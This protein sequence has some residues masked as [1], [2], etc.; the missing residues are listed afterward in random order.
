MKISEVIMDTG[1]LVAALSAKDEFHGWAQGLLHE[2][3]VP[4]VTCEAVLSE[5]FFRLRKNEAAT[6]SLCELIDD[7]AFKILPVRALGAVA[8]YIARYR[9]D[10]ADACLVALS[11][12]FPAAT[13]VTIDRRDFTILRRFGRE[14]IPFIAP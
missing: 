5:A 13:L 2:L 7:S 11:E 12:Q 3:P 10:F 6:A 9:V 4:W 14:A 1:P 8:R